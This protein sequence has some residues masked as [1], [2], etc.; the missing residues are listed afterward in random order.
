M[1][2]TFKYGDDY[3]AL[4]VESGSVHMLDR[5]GYDAITLVAEAERR[6]EDIEKAA[7]GTGLYGEIKELIDEGLLFSG[8]D[9]DVKRP[10]NVLKAACLH[11]AHDC[12]LRCDYCF[13]KGGAFAGK[14][15]LMSADTARAAID[16]I[17]G[18][19]GAR[20]N[21]EIDFFGGEP[22]LNFEVLKKTVE[23]ARGIE[24]Q[25]GKRFR[26]TVTTNAYRL[27]DEMK[28]YIDGNMDNIV[29]SIDGRQH[30]HDAVRKNAG[31]SGSYENVVANAKGLLLNRKGEYYI[32]GTYTADN[33]DFSRDVLHIADMGF[34]G[35]SI[36]PVVTKGDKALKPEHLETI[37]AEYDTLAQEYEKRRKEGRGFTF[38]HFMVD[39]NAGPCLQKRIRGCGAGTEY[40][41]IA[42]SGDVY[43]C[44][45]FVGKPEYRLGSVYNGKLNADISKAF[46]ECNIFNIENCSKCWAK[47]Y[48]SGGCA[49]ANYNINGDIM[50]P[51]ELGCA[52]Q[53]KR[54]EIAIAI[55]AKEQAEET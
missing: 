53:K 41:A 10:A 18:I 9:G 11:L 12:N 20:R 5:Q 16:F 15:E 34:K 43:P 23:Y 55:A 52:L 1:V 47:Y 40:V 44:H 50:K 26:F 33:L 31:G 4:D 21:I 54:L 46:D 49:A 3:F 48:C 45:Q 29:V 13:A 17:A 14:R 27:T 38:F 36:E 22:M 32:R 35:V 42:P 19:S 30:V 28:E 8:P 39:L 25:R 51:Y 24:K 7:E 6:G 2:H 37:F